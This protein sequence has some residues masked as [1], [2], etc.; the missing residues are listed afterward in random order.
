ML[1]I[2]NDFSNMKIQTIMA[3]LTMAIVAFLYESARNRAQALLLERKRW[4]TESESRY[5]QANARLE[6]EVAERKQAEAASLR[7]KEAAEAANR[8]KSTFLATMSHEL[9]TPLTGVLGML[10]LLQHT[11]LT[12]QQRGFVTMAGRSGRSLLTLINTI[13]DV[14]KLESDQLDLACV[15]FNLPQTVTEAV[16][17]FRDRAW[18]QGLALTCQLGDK[19]PSSVRGDPS[20]LR[21]VFLNLLDNALKF[22]TQGAVEVRLSL[23]GQT[24]AQVVLRGEVHDT[25]PGIAPAEQRR[26]FDAF[27]QADSSTTRLHGGAGLGLTLASQLVR[28]MN[29][30]MGIESTP[31]QGA[32]FWFTV[33]L[34]TVAEA[35]PALTPVPAAT[36][37][38]YDVR[39]LLVEDNAVNRTV[40]SRMLKHLGCQVDMAV[41]GNEAL[42]AVART[43]Y[44]LVFMDC[45]MPE[46]DGFEV[47]RMI[48]T[49]EAKLGNRHL[50]IVALT[51]HAMESDRQ[52]CQAAGMD[53]YLSKPF[54]LEQVQEVLVRWTPSPA[55]TDPVPE[56]EVGEDTQASSATLDPHTLR[57]L[58]E[59]QSPGERDVLG[60]VIALYQDESSALLE[61][62]RE[63]VQQQDSAAVQRA[64][65]SLKSCS[66]N[67]G[68]LKL[69]SWCREL[70]AKGRMGTLEGIEADLA[71]LEAEYAAVRSALATEMPR[72]AS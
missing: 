35:T 47:T 65:H 42:D 58:R 68:A 66:G 64:A 24:A 49:N 29:G 21:Q 51:A 1:V 2:K 37:E 63:A 39:V 61:A 22:T 19:L 26:L 53:D 28:L 71:S 14:S 55:G 8:A 9:R 5:R 33:R 25:G 13:L 48:R 57:T 72:R 16:A 12:D 45:Q 4:L 44:D 17:L 27:E 54:T 3:F 60:E 6:R 34:G 40:A 70:E 41:D 30:T 43:A 67:V 7:A 10:D 56:R 46:L 52:A 62:L 20:R 11:S 38:A 23:I 69:V 59:L 31:G 15:V 36:P 50:L 18:R 32:T